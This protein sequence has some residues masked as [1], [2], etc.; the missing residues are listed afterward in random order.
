MANDFDL[1]VIGAGPAGLAAA[2]QASALG[3]KTVLFDEQPEPGGQIFRS[4]ERVAQQRPETLDP[5]ARAGLQLVRAVRDSQVEYLAGASVWNVTDDKT[6][7]YQVAG[8]LARTQTQSLLV[9]TGAME[10]P[11]PILGWTLPGV[12][13]AAAADL[14]W[15]SSGVLPSGACILCGSGP[16]LLATACHLLDAGAELVAFLDT[17]PRHATVRASVHLPRALGAASDLAR[18][19][20]MIK[21]LRQ[22]RAALYRGVHGVAAEGQGRFQSVSFQSGGRSHRLSGEM[23]L[24]HNGL[25]PNLQVSHLLGCD[26]E[27]ERVQRYFRPKLGPWGLSS[28][29]WVWFAG[30]GAGIAG[31]RVAEHAGRLAAL[32]IAVHHGKLCSKERQQ[33]LKLVNRALAIRPLLERLY[34][35]RAEL[36]APD[37][38]DT[39]ICRCEEITVG[40]IRQALILGDR[41]VD[42]VKART[43][44]GM[45]PCQ[46]RMCSSTLRELIAAHHQLAVKEV[47]GQKIRAPLRPIRLDALASRGGES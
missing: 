43:R 1:A 47:P 25:M 41:S 31:A 5:E 14:L 12:M 22:S 23:L 32:D 39:L 20:G 15:R 3:L 44:C 36:L 7:E 6:I 24:L 45:G 28:Q 30:D 17:T 35:P 19:L 10:R 9:A 34:Q 27:F 2:Q 16:L 46:G 29:D 18:G 37:H 38:E 26:H 40:E 8:R 21:K 13:G 4:V 33:E 42:I 11:M